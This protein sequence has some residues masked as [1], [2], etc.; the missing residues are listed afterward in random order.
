[1]NEKKTYEIKILQ[2]D[3]DQVPEPKIGE[4]ENSAINSTMLGTFKK[5]LRTNVQ[6]AKESSPWAYGAIEAAEYSMGFAKRAAEDYIDSWWLLEEDY[7]GQ[8]NVNNA[9]TV[10]GIV[11]NIGKSTINGALTGAKVG[12]A[13]GAVVGAA[14]GLGKSVTDTV[15]GARKVLVDEYRSLEQTAYSQYFSGVRNGLISGSRGTEN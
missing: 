11:S 10:I 5:F 3:G 15:F 2:E 13:V 4:Y 6:R 14:I 9:K 8:T 1:M 7:V 12:G